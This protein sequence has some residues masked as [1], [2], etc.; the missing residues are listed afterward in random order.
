MRQRLP[1]FSMPTG[2]AQVTAKLELVVARSVEPLMGRLW[3]VSHNGG[4]LVLH[5]HRQ[6]VVPVGSRLQIRDPTSHAVHHLEAELRWCAPLSHTTFVGMLFT[7]GPAP[8][9]TFLAAYMRSSWTEEVP[10]SS[11][12]WP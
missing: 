10:V 3:D 9:E 12:S 5:G 8:A 4:C 7:G 1:R 6:I 2:V 11:F